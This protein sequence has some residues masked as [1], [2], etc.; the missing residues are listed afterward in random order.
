MK[1][2]EF[3]ITRGINEHQNASIERNEKTINYT[4]N[5][6]LSYIEIL[7]ITS[8][9]NIVSEFFD[10]NAAVVV[11]A[12]GIVAT[13]LGKTLSEAI[14][15]AM[16][17]NP[18]DFINST[19]VVSAEVDSDTAKI[20]KQV[21]TIV[22]PK[23]TKNATE[24]LEDSEINY[25]TINTPLKDYK[26]FLS[27][28]IRVTPLGTLTQTPNLC[29]LDKDS[30]KVVSKTKPTV[31]L[32]EDAVF[33]WKIVKHVTSQAIVI[34]KDLKTSAITQGMQSSS[35]EGALNYACEM[36][37]DAILASDMPITL[38]D[39]NAAVQCRIGLIIVPSA[40][41][42]IIKAADKYNLALIT[43]SKTNITM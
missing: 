4:S 22:A 25:V 21:K 8:G 39:V 24:F 23:F 33:A 43:T 35:C 5:K 20:L 41:E 2:E 19:L 14:M 1:L 38:H 9:L 36:A 26:K 37:K 3:K 28:E 11:S 29:E 31:E 30:F 27:N 42:E 13:A 34:A 40:D 15:N 10:V 17:S 7:N 16:D 18:I 12:T 6:K 32:I